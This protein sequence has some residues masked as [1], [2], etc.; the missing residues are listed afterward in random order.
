MFGK[1]KSSITILAI[2]LIVLNSYGAIVIS[3]AKKTEPPKVEVEVETEVPKEIPVP[4]TNKTKYQYIVTDRGKLLVVPH[5]ILF[6]SNSSY[7]DLNKYNDTINYVS[8]LSQDTNI[9]NIIIEG[10][11]SYNE[12][13][14]LENK[15]DDILFLYNRKTIEDL[16]YKRCETVYFNIKSS[17]LYKFTNYALKDLLNTYTNNEENR[18]VN[19]ILIENTND[20]N[21]YTNYINNLKISNN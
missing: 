11:I 7:L 18:R 15:K 1:R 12:N 16:S 6:T 5:A 3:T 19:F 13:Q 4:E 9:M 14:F 10:H 21:I 20:I 2:L 8:S 17:N